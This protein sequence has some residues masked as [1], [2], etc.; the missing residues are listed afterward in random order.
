ML[1]YPVVFQ[2]GIFL[3]CNVI[4]SLVISTLSW[5]LTFSSSNSTSLNKSASSL[6]GSGLSHNILQNS[7]A[8]SELDET[9]AGVTFPPKILKQ[10]FLVA[11]GKFVL[12]IL[13]VSGGITSQIL[14]FCRNSL[15]QLLNNEFKTFCFHS[16]FLP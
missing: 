15:F 16:V 14:R 5:M 12:P 11:S 8:S 6:Y 10:C 3:S 1:S 7:F 9:C 2:F 13:V 4:S